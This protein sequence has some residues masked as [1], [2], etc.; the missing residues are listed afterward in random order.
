MSFPEWVCDWTLT[1]WSAGVRR[2]LHY[3]SRKLAGGYTG[4]IVPGRVLGVLCGS[5]FIDLGNPDVRWVDA[6]SC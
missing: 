2:S 1:G 6:F 4:L 5:V 3:I